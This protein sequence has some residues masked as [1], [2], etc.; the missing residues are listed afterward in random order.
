MSTIAVS[1]R[2]T[3]RSSGVVAHPP[4]RTSV[5]SRGRVTACNVERPAVAVGAW[6]RLKVAVVSVVAIVGAVVG[7]A[8]YVEAVRGEPAVDIVSAEGAW[9]H[10][11]R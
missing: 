7:V 4:R 6:V 2:G 5:A 3:R 9:A 10:V 1:M 8:G 11:E